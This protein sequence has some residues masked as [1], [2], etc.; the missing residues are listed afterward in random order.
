V[1]KD[2]ASLVPGDR[3]LTTRAMAE[4]AGILTTHH[5]ALGLP[6]PEVPLTPVLRAVLEK[7]IEATAVVE[8]E[9][10]RIIP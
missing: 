9:T 8:K 4:T 2:F 5:A 7:Q 1:G 10:E 6:K 3:S